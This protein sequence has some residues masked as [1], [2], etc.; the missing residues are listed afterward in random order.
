[1]ALIVNVY[2]LVVDAVCKGLNGTGCY[3][4]SLTFNPS[5]PGL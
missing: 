2:I 5:A 4:N 1:M 3:G